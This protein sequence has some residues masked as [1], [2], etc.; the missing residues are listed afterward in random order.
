MRIKINFFFAETLHGFSNERG[1]RERREGEESF[2]SFPGFSEARE[3]FRNGNKLLPLFP[4]HLSMKE[5][6]R[7]KFQRRPISDNRGF[8]SSNFRPVT[9]KITKYRG[10]NLETRTRTIICLSVKTR[11]FSPS[12]FAVRRGVLLL[13][14][15]LFSFFFNKADSANDERGFPN[16]RQDRLKLSKNSTVILII[17]HI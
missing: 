10:V 14:Y 2:R 1:E 9:L 8:R 16:V 4:L 15:F 5:R 6:Q 11:G 17:V 7:T 13:K 3:E 12:F